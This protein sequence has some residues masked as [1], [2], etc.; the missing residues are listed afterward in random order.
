M[1]GR[2]LRFPFLGY[3]NTFQSIALKRF[4]KCNWSS[5]SVGLKIQRLFWWAW[6]NQVSSL[7]VE[8][9]PAGRGKKLRESQS[10]RKTYIA[11]VS[12]K[13]KGGTWV[14]MQVAAG[15]RRGSKQTGN[16]ERDT[17]DLQLQKIGFFLQPKWAMIPA[18]PSG[19]QVRLVTTQP[20]PPG[21]L[22]YRTCT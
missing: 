6:P 19:L 22:T 14:A 11:L 2:I 8:F 18:W 17:S 3:S 15:R 20:N 12:L 16:K 9:S 5:K 10:L 13:V 4:C 7:Q 21:F 1:L